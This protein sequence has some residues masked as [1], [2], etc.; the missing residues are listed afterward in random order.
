MSFDCA[1]M[2]ISSLIVVINTTGQTLPFWDVCRRG[3][4]SSRRHKNPRE[5]SLTPCCPELQNIN[6]C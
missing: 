6:V 1:G 5:S 3:A 2:I 4:A